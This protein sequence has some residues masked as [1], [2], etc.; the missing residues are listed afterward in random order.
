M[1]RLLPVLCV[2]LAALAG[3]GGDDPPTRT[4]R[5]G[6]GEPVRVSGSEYTFD[7]GRIIVAGGPARL[8]VTLDNQG[9]LAHN[10]KVLDGDAEIG[11]LSSFPA[12]EERTTTVAVEPGRY[13]L[14]CTV[15]DHEELGMEGELQVRP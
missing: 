12:G 3:C 13:R 15:A 10:I 4:V 5:V 7:P 14:V 6:A 11:G 2:A 8:R 9:D 1:R